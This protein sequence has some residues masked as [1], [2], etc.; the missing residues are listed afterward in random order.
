[1]VGARRRARVGTQRLVGPWIVPF[2]AAAAAPVAILWLAGQVEADAHPHTEVESYAAAQHF[3][4]LIPPGV[5]I[6]T[7]GAPCGSA[8]AARTA[9]N[10]SFMFY[11]LDRKGFN[12]CVEEQSMSRIDGFVRRGAEYFVAK[13]VLVHAQPDFAGELGR[14]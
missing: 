10:L 9:Y 6:L 5:R 12:V 2:L 7:S 11:W 13:D 4:P 1:V 14:R 3:A 8:M